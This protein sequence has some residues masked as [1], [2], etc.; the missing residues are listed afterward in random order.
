MEKTLEKELNLLEEILLEE[1]KELELYRQHSETLSET[2]LLEKQ[3]RIN[4][5]IKIAK[6]VNSESHSLKEDNRKNLTSVLERLLNES[7][8]A[9]IKQNADGEIEVTV[10]DSIY[11][12][13]ILARLQIQKV[14]DHL[15]FKA[16]H[17][18]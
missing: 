5:L 12:P 2:D 3:E 7:A 9:H 8:S 11:R 17:F 16:L 4:S 13:V 1:E 6:I 15:I 10:Y 14:F 18:Y